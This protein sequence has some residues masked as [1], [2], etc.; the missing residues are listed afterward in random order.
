M[1]QTALLSLCTESQ[2]N[3]VEQT[4]K[5][6][7]KHLNCYVPWRWCRV[8]FRT[9]VTEGGSCIC[10]SRRDIAEGQNEIS[11]ERRGPNG[12]RPRRSGCSCTWKMNLKLN[13]KL[14]TY[15]HFHVIGTI[16]NWKYVL[17]DENGNLRKKEKRDFWT[18]SKSEANSLRQL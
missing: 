11:P 7:K 4:F 6:V 9:W 2:M 10:C 1:V 14:N 5:S 3:P 12:P 17:A 16:F 13:E 15:L 8:Y 18:K